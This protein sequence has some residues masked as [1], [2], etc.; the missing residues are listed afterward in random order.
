MWR[1]I[2]RN[3]IGAKRLASEIGL[4]Y[5]LVWYWTKGKSMPSRKTLK[6]LKEAVLKYAPEK[7][8]QFEISLNKDL[9]GM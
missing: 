4:T 9:I 1:E 8:Q 5:Q 2:I 3:D 7:Y 6:S